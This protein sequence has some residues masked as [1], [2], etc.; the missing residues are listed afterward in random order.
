[1]RQSEKYE[2]LYMARKDERLMIAPL[3]EFYEDLLKIDA[4]A[5]AQTIAGQGKLL[6]CE[7]L[8]QRQE[9][10]RSRIEYLATKRGVT[11]DEL[12]M[13]VLK[14]EA[15]KLEAEEIAIDIV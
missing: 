6:L 10:I 14:G 5:T 3:G 1:M 2:Y 7:R 13:Q 9:G 8:M 11:I 15:K 12:W 4:W